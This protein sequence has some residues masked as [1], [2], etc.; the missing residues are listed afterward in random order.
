MAMQ[1]NAKIEV[2]KIKRSKTA[3]NGAMPSTV[4]LKIILSL[5]EA[6]INVITYTERT[7]C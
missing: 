2:N 7:H 1:A 3:R 6:N 4:T 5:A